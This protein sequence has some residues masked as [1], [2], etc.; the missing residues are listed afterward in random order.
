MKT[1]GATRSWPCGPLVR[2][3]TGAPVRLI[4]AVSGA[5]IL[6][7]PRP[8]RT[9]RRLSVLEVTFPHHRRFIGLNYT[10]LRMLVK[11]ELRDNLFPV[12]RLPG[13]IY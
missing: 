8:A 12:G 2:A 11:G 5:E 3:V 6:L 4:A 10:D 7:P 9:F 1:R 13:G